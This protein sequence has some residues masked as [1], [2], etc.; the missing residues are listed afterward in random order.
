VYRTQ[1]D[2]YCFSVEGLQKQLEAMKTEL[3]KV[4][5]DMKSAVEDVP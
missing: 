4:E 3:N 5:E 1:Q 2:L